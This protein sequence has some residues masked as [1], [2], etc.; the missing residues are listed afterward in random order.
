MA[1]QMFT[2]RVARWSAEH[3]WRSIAAWV[4]FVALCIGVGGAAGTKTADFDDN[5]KG[6]LAVY[7][8]IVDDAGF[9]RPSTENVLITAREGTLDPAEGAAVA[10][11]VQQRMGALRE[12]AKVSDPVPSP[13]GTATLVSVDIAGDRDTADE[14]VQPLLDATAAVQA[15]H[16]DLRVE[17]VG[18]QSLKKALSDTVGKDFQRAELIS[19]PVT[20]LIMLVAF[21]A[22]IA[23]GVPVLLAMSAVGA[24]IGLSSLASYLVPASDNTSSMILLIGMAVGVDYSLFYVR[25]EREERAK[26]RTHLSAVEVAAAT[27]GH[28]IVVSGI[29]VVVAMSGMFVA[30][31]AIFSSMAIGSILVVLVAVLG[32]ITVLPALLAKLGRWIDK[33]RVPLIWRLAARSNGEPRVWKAILRPTLRRPAAALLIAVLGLLALAYPALS[34]KLNSPSEADLPRS[35]PIMQS[36]DRMTEAFPSTGAVHAIAVRLPAD[37]VAQGEAAVTALTDRIKADPAF[38]HDREPEV[39]RAKEGRIVLISAPI[40]V[41]ANDPA[42]DSSLTWLRTTALPQTIG[43]V[44]GAEFAV[45]GQTAGENDFV[46]SMNESL[47]W[48]ILVVLVLTFI[49]MTWTFRAPIIALSSIALNMLSA[50]A[51]YG[52][53]V[54]VFQN[55]WAEGLLG[56]TSTGGITAW[57]PLMLFVVLFGLSMDYHVFVVSRIREARLAG[58]DNRAAVAKG[59]T[60]SAGVVTSAAVVMVGVFSV[61]A[62]LSTID[63]KQMGVGLATAILLDATLIRAVV[64]PSLMAVLG[65]RNWWTPRFLRREDGLVPVSAEEETRQLD[66]VG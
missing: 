6:E 50:G 4:V 39:T 30:N 20:L 27:S 54:L 43:T 7:Q 55:T 15:A 35:I 18:G 48:V 8:Q 58:L 45:S 46:D 60:S 17:Q 52:V 5:V 31:D 65:E 41:T 23:A 9:D 22:I 33:P 12:V 13:T 57:L 14:R 2:V 24:A 19:L 49:M 11:E 63:M 29:A 37:K 36:Y 59:I 1:R 44:A 38:A 62:T 10:A 16:P 53:L 47:P 21:G 32:S 56:F 3:P 64:L 40:P 26:G 42:A 28:A 66:P 51:A 25:R 34:M 61:F